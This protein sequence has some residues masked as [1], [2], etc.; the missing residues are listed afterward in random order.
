[1]E[2]SYVVPAS[3]PV[4]KDILKL[5]E[6]DEASVSASVS[7]KVAA[8]TLTQVTVYVLKENKVNALKFQRLFSGLFLNKMLVIRAGIHKKH[9]RIANSKDPDWTASSEA[10]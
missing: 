10:V 8:E 1:M 6:P 5:L 3:T 2:H 9:D 4:V 7:S